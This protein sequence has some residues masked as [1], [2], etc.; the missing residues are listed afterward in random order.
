MRPMANKFGVLV[1]QKEGQ[2]NWK[3]VFPF[4]WGKQARGNSGDQ[5]VFSSALFYTLT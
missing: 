3:V 1:E 5:G 2:C 4:V